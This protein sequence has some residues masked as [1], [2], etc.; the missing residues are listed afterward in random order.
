[1][2]TTFQ[3]TDL[4]GAGVQYNYANAS[5]SLFVLS[6]TTIASSNGAAIY[7]NFANAGLQIDGAVYATAQAF[8][9]NSGGADV[10]IGLNGIVAS[11]QSYNT[12]TAVHLSDGQNTIANAGQITSLNSIGVLVDSGDNSVVNSGSI[13]AASAV[14]LGLFGSS[15]DTLYNSG[16]LIAVNSEGVGNDPAETRLSHGV[17]TEGSNTIIT[18]AASG[19]ILA[20]GVS[21]AGVHIGSGGNGSIVVNYGLIGSVQGFGVDF[22]DMQNGESA[23]L[24]NHGTVSGALLSFRGNESSETVLNTGQMD[25]DV[26]LNAGDDR[27]ENSGSVLGYVF[28]DFGADV[29]RGTGD[30]TVAGDVFGGAGEDRLFGGENGDDLFGGA[31]NDLLRG[32]AGDDDLEGGAGEDNIRGNLGDDFLH[33]NQDNDV[34]HG[35]RGDDTIKGGSGNDTITGGKG[36]DILSGQS[37][38]DVFVFNRRTGDDEITDF[39]NNTD[40]LDLTAFAV[41]SRQDLTNADAIVGNGAGSIIDL[42]QIGGDGVIYVEDMSV[43]QWSASDFIFA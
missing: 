2:T 23:V 4:I 33:G 19:E 31:D 29:Y 24:V 16:T 42:T 39:A 38:A 27:F 8:F 12:Q 15:N 37:G 13:V 40:K 32:R 20:G 30:S 6:G 9:L 34:L 3:N 18:N 28:L 10:S 43:A 22:F 17:H 7:S 5:D 21:K 1:M 14:F 11:S 35:G 25:G 36:E 41:S 26:F